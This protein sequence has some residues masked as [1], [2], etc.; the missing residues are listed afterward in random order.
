MNIRVDDRV[1][2]ISWKQK[3]KEIELERKRVQSKPNQIWLCTIITL[4]ITT[5]II[6]VDIIITA[7]IR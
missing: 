6:M 3:Q 5:A 2:A 7:F 4:A 1:D